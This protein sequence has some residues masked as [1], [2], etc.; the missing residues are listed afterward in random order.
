MMVLIGQYAGMSAAFAVGGALL[1]MF[2]AS[3]ASLQRAQLWM[4][5]P[6]V[7]V[8]ISTLAMRE[9]PRMD[10]EIANPSPRQSLLEL[11]RYRAVVAPL[12]VGLVMAEMA[13]LAVLT[14]ASPALARSFELA[15]ERIGAIMAVALFLSGVVGPIAGGAL[16]D[17]CQRIGGPRLT[18]F[19]LSLLA[20]LCAPAA[21]FPVMPTVSSASVLLVTFMT[22]V[23]AI[24]VV[25]IALFTIVIPNELRGLCVAALAG[26]Q[27]VF[28]VA[29]APVTVSVLS[30]AMGGGAMVGTALAIVGSATSLLGAACFLF[31]RRYFS[32]AMKLEVVRV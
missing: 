11:W 22:F 32:G 20:L 27:V 29:L 1:S 12:L 9:P 2:G 10:R 21:L 17:V 16:A 7:A 8:I 30:N 5:L 15:P 14:W 26:V 24:L 4:A 18:M 19:S 6:L 3:A 28:G 25:G 13:V 23:G 31:G